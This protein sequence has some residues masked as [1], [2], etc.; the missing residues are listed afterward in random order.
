MA[1]TVY[2]KPNCPQCELTKRDMDILGIEYETVDLTQ[3]QDEL[4][5]LIGLGHRGAPVV[6]TEHGSW[7]GYDQEKIK[8]LVSYA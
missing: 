1:I 8:G 5:R 7:S 6:E 4:E 3:R 2:S